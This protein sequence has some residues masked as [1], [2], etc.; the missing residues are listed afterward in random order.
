MKLYKF[1]SLNN[2]ITLLF[3]T[4]MACITIVDEKQM[5]VK[6]GNYEYSLS[7]PDVIYKLPVRLEEISGLDY[8]GD[9]ILLCVEDEE[10][11]LYFYNTREK[12]VTREIKF[13]KSGDYEGV[14]H[15]DNMAY[16]VKSNG[17]LY[18]FPIDLDD[19][20]EAI[21]IETAFT[22]SNNVEGLCPGHKKKEIYLACKENAEVDNNSIKGRAVYAFDLKKGKLI[23]PPY[24]H[25]TSEVF[26]EAL[27][28]KGL[29]PSQYMPFKPSGI[30]LHPI[31]GDV[32]IIGSVGKLLIVLDQSGKIKSVAPLSRK[33]FVQPEGICFD[34]QGVLFISSEGRGND[35][36]ILEFNP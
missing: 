26:N 3:L 2:Y 25:L 11:I 31:T 14:T 8:L 4:G 27:K 15:I 20:V 23:D 10:G 9:R 29:K 24:I 34:E 33:L 12:K 16:V 7:D 19:E 22:S 28:Q 21:K 32:F 30:A 18:T 5:V 17:N 1:R 35:G 13:A 6:S 36:Y